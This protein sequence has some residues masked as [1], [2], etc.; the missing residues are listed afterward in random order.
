M[1][2]L[3]YWL[4]SIIKEIQVKLKDKSMILEKIVTVFNKKIK[5]Y[6][7]IVIP[8]KEQFFILHFLLVNFFGQF[9]FLEFFQYISLS[10]VKS[11]FLSFYFLTDRKLL[12]FSIY[13]NIFSI[14]LRF[15]IIKMR[16]LFFGGNWKSNNTLAKTQGLVGSL[17]DKLEFD[18]A[19]VGTCSC[20]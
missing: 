1:V 20:I 4:S 2:N 13:V 3:S 16:K 14:L 5:F 17:I 19:Q 15:D 18:P 9:L 7:N 8:N 12:S 10:L 11:F 6:K